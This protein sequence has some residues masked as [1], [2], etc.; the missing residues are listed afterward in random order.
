MVHG[1]TMGKAKAAPF[2]VNNGAC[3]GCGGFFALV[4]NDPKTSSCSAQDFAACC[5]CAVWLKSCG[6]HEK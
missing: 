3:L 5:Y 6:G 2:M 1:S 4:S